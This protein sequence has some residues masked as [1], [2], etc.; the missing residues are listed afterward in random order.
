MTDP[1]PELAKN[2]GLKEIMCRILQAELR[3][4]KKFEGFTCPTE[5]HIDLLD[6]VADAI[7]V[8]V[9]DTTIYPPDE[10]TGDCVFCRDYIFHTWD[11]VEREEDVPAFIDFLAGE[12][13]SI[14]PMI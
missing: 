5:D 14:N 10:D 1:K 9:D 13:I 2:R 3:H 7:G 4:N 8:P 11:D 12:S 6:I